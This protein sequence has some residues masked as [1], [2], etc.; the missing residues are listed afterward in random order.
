MSSSTAQSLLLS[1]NWNGPEHMPPYLRKAKKVHK[2][3]P[4]K[5]IKDWDTQRKKGKDLEAT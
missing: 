3:N 1:N 5:E 4:T 2:E